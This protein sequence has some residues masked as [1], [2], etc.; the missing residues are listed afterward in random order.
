MCR[1]RYVL[2]YLKTNDRIYPYILGEEAFQIY[3]GWHVKNVGITD[4]RLRI[5][6]L[7]LLG[8]KV[9]NKVPDSES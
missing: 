3:N 4:F 5:Y 8:K 6:Y 1:T 2:P 9:E 7:N